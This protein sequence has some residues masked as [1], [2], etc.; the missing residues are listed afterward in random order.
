[1]VKDTIETHKKLV[2]AEITQEKLIKLRDEI[3]K[4]VTSNSSPEGIIL[5]RINSCLYRDMNNN[6]VK[7]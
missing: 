4:Y 3:F 5:L 2:H 7:E 1:M 6:L